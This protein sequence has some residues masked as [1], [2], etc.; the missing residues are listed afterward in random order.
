MG[1]A[2]LAR[3][4]AQQFHRHYAAAEIAA[5]KLAM[6]HGRVERL[7]LGEGEC[8]GQQVAGDISVLELGVAQS[9]SR[10]KLAARRV[11]EHLANLDEAAREGPFSGGGAAPQLNQITLEASALD[12]EDHRV[13]GNFGPCEAVSLCAP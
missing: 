13:D 9:G 7:E 1:A 6:K 12:R 8:P 5:V 4:L 2:E 3:K 11:V 10:V